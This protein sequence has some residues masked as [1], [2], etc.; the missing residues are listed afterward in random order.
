MQARCR[1][2]GKT[3]AECE[4]NKQEYERMKATK[5]HLDLLLGTIRN[6]GLNAQVECTLGNLNLTAATYPTALDLVRAILER[7]QQL[8]KAPTSNRGRFAIMM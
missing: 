8:R 5:I 1:A 3:T 2:T 6:M 4:P 7:C